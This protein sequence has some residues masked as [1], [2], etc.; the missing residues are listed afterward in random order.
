MLSLVS[1]YL[2]IIHVIINSDHPNQLT[3]NY[4]PSYLRSTAVGHLYAVLRR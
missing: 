1:V 4:I 3:E 2:L